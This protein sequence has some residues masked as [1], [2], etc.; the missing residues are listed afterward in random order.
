MNDLEVTFGV[1]ET[2]GGEKFFHPTRDHEAAKR[3]VSWDEALE[4][5]AAINGEPFPLKESE[6]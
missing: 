1:F 6:N 3:W 5:G 4:L 2:V